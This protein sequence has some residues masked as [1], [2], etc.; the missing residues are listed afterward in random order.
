MIWITTLCLLAVALWLFFN[1]LNERRWVEAHSHDETVAS[2]EGLL[3]SLTGLTK[4]ANPSSQGGTPGTPL[5]RAAKKLK[6]GSEKLGEQVTD[7][8]KSAAEMYERA[9]Q[10]DGALG[11]NSTVGRL[12]S[13]T[14]EKASVLNQKLDAGMKSA[15]GLTTGSS[16]GNGNGQSFLN[17]AAATSGRVTQKVAQRVKSSAD[18]L[19]GKT[20]ASGD[21]SVISK[22]AG[23]VSDGMSAVDQKLDRSDR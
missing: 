8:K 1:A 4:T 2:D 5:E 14:R 18:N 12:A 17:K 16:D 15:S 21:E 3:P 10:S 22:I 13:K 6:T 7:A 11:K 23:K 19:S 20:N 9:K